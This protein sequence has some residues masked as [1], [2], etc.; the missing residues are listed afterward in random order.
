MSMLRDNPTGA[1][2]ASQRRSTSRVP[3]HHRRSS[4]DRTCPALRLAALPAV[5][6]IS[7]GFVFV[8]AFLDKTFGLGYGTPSARLINGGSPTNAS[9]AT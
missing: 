7:M 5:L 9:S 1:P 2:I 6:R 8:W 3:T 4:P